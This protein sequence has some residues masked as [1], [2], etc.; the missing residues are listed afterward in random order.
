V[1]DLGHR[2]GDG[3]ALATELRRQPSTRDTPQVFAG[4]DPDEVARVR[5]LLPDAHYSDWEG[6]ATQLRTAIERPS[7]EPVDGG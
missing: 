3:I 2:P 5:Q 4:G 1:I 6:I 7:Q